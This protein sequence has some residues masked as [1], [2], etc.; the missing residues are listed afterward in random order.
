MKLMEKKWKT[1]ILSDDMIAYLENSREF[2]KNTLEGTL[3]RW[4]D[5]W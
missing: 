5:M 4:L 2:T 1:S 3:V